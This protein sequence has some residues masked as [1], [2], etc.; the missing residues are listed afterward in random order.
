[1]K[2]LETKILI[3][4]ILFA[5]ISLFAA[6]NPFEELTD[7][8]GDVVD[9][10]VGDDNDEDEQVGTVVASLTFPAL[11]SVTASVTV[12]TKKGDLVKDDTKVR[13]VYSS[14][15]SGSVFNDDTQ[16]TVSGAVTCI[17]IENTVNLQTTQLSFV[18]TS[19]GVSSDPQF[20]FLGASG[21][22]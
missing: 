22:T 9:E 3:L 12:F 10:V 11:N 7:A 16:P 15:E 19:E 5:F 21:T 14:V 6:C 2:V 13:C 8:Y 20:F 17:T 18:A 1:M 4:F